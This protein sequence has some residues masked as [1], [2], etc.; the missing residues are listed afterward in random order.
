MILTSLLS[1]AGCRAGSGATSSFAVRMRD[2]ACV[3]KFR[4]SRGGWTEI[5]L[6][7]HVRGCDHRNRG[8]NRIPLEAGGMLKLFDV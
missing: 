3:G 5:F 4:G 7:Q 2:L 6:R 8:R 1:R